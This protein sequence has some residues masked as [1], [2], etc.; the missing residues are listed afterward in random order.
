[1]TEYTFCPSNMGCG[2]LVVVHDGVN[3]SFCCYPCW[4]TYWEA[5]DPQHEGEPGDYGHSEQ[6]DARQAVRAGMDITPV[7][8]RDWLLIG[9][10]PDEIRRATQVR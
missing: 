1:M 7:Q 5:N 6:C 9:R 8:G 10:V 2:S 4:Q 3:I